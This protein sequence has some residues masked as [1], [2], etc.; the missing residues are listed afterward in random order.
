MEKADIQTAFSRAGLARVL[1]DL[2]ALVQPAI[3]LS[4]APV[5]ESSMELGTSKIGGL[6]DLPPGMSWPEWKGLPQSFLAQFRLQDL[7]EFD[8]EHVLPPHGM[9]WFFYDARQQTFGDAPTDQ[10]GWHVSFLADE[11]PWLERASWPPRLPTGSRF[12]ACSVTFAS[13]MTLSHAP[14]LDIPHYDWTEAE[15]LNYERLLATF[16]T[17]TEHTAIQHHLLGHADTLQDDMRLQCQLVSHGVTDLDDPRSEQLTPGARDWRLL[18]QLDSDEHTGMRWASD[19][20]L[21]Y[22]IPQIALQEHL[23]EAAWLVLQ[24]E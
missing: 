8:V 14:E 5:A 4:T 19:G 6:P 11:H 1:K 21:Y 24:S 20:T 13:Q 3:K 15:Q 7:R 22:W 12:Q 16:P 2:D 23:F 18:L 9:L 10:G 17:P